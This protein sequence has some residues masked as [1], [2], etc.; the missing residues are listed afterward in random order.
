MRLIYLI[1]LNLLLEF[2]ASF[3]NLGYQVKS[4][5]ILNNFREWISLLSLIDFAIVTRG[6]LSSTVLNRLRN[7][8]GQLYFMLYFIFT[9]V[10]VDFSINGLELFTWHNVNLT[11]ISFRLRNLSG[12]RCLISTSHVVVEHFQVYLQE[13]RRA[14]SFGG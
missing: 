1:P 10:I 2:N 8:I 9:F 7:G 3:R 12:K 4:I 11:L 14:F 5:I 6:F 13:S